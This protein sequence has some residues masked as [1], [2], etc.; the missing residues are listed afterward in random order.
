M[1][2]WDKTSLERIVAMALILSLA[3]IAAAAVFFAMAWGPWAGSD[4]V[5]YLEAAR[6]LVAGRGLVVVRASGSVLPL[7]ARPPLYS[8]V[9]ASMIFVGLDPLAGVRGF[10]AMLL[11]LF[12]G[13]LGI[14]LLRSTGRLIVPVL[15]CLFVVSAQAV[16]DSFTGMMSEP[17]FL[18]IMIGQLLS[19]AHYLTTGKK[20]ALWLSAVLAGLA[21]LTRYAGA[22]SVLVLAVAVVGWGEGS[23]KKRILLAVSSLAIAAVPYLIWS[24]HLI[25]RGVTP[26]VYRF[27][28][29]DARQAFGNARVAVINA[30]WG[31][32]PW[33]AP[34]MGMADRAK[35][36]LTGIFILA[37]AG[38]LVYVS[39]TR[40]LAGGRGKSG[41]VVLGGLFVAFSLAHATV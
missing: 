28:L 9:L 7:N 13:V 32:F 12:A 35:T 31:W 17:V 26:G 25:T 23:V 30:S 16:L 14:S 36:A 15:A 10:N 5:E 4:S 11:A 22:A 41:T 27:D 37:A 20:W 38:A 8:V 21:W 19:L 29:G 24:S 18:V 40:G 6:N 1:R 39:R 3:T 34:L 33:L 2:R